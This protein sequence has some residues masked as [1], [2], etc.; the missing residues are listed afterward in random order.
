MLKIFDNSGSDGYC[1]LEDENGS[2]GEISGWET[3]AI[4][5][6]QKPKITKELIEFASKKVPLEQMFNSR[7]RIDF[8]EKYSPSGWCFVRGCPFPDHRDST[9][10]FHYNKEEDRFFCFG[11]NRGGRSVQFISYM[12]NITFSDAARIL[13]DSIDISTDFYI[14]AE[15]NNNSRID[16]LILDFSNCVHDFIKNNNTQEGLSFMEMTTQMLDIYLQKHMPSGTIDETNL[17]ERLRK[18]KIRLQE[19]GR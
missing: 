3:E 11:C 7:Y 5:P 4:F 2:V 17:T 13:L 6:T 14:E 10:S 18:L 19:Y 9:P 1:S 12:E 15:E 8:E 16:D